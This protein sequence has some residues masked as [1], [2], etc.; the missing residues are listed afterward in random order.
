MNDVTL[1]A[2]VLL[3]IAAV[4]LWLTAWRALLFLA[5]GTVRVEVE[6]PADATRVPDELADAVSALRKLG[7]TLLGAHS[8]KYP[9]R[10]PREFIDLVK[11]NVVASLRVGR[12][13]GDEVTLWSHAQG[14]FVITSNF[15]RPSREVPGRYLSGAID[16][17]SYERLLN[18]HLRRVPE[19]NATGRAENVEAHVETV[20]AWFR[21]AGKPELRQAHAVALLWS[22][23]AV[24]MVGAAVFKLLNG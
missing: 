5:P 24:G 15:K 12:D 10:A 3:A 9:L 19:I 17:A 21:G 13:E 8:E 14:R 2:L 7:F 6:S 22:L 4:A 1:E 20:R 16:G 23:G 18:V 11:E